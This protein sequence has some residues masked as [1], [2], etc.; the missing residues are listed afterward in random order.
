[1][2]D[3]TTSEFLNPILTE[4]KAFY[5]PIIDKTVNAALNCDML[6]QSNHTRNAYI[7]RTGESFYYYSTSPAT[8]TLYKELDEYTKAAET[9]PGELDAWKYAEEKRIQNA[10]RD[11]IIK[12]YITA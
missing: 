8:K 5:T 4:I 1:M 9:E 7:I 6:L 2:K 12:E 3:F 11:A 10:I